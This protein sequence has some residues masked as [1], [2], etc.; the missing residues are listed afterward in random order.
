MSVLVPTHHFV[1]LFNVVPKLHSGGTQTR[2][3]Q[4]SDLETIVPIPMLNPSGEQNAKNTKHKPISLKA[5]SQTYINIAKTIYQSIL[6]LLKNHGIHH[7]HHDKGNRI[8][9]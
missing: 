7:D 8:H 9:H 2:V 1:G 6:D 5:P 3:C 4:S